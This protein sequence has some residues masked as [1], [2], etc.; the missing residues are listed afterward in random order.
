MKREDDENAM[1]ITQQFRSGEAMVYDF[2]SVAGR[3]T[4]RVSGRG[5]EETGPPSEWRIEA[6]TSTSPESVVVAEW[7]PT[8][9]DALRAVGRA[10]RAKSVAH[11]LPGIDWESVARAMSAVRAL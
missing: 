9:A 5:G 7:G 4:V 3:L 8:R 6:C 10:W 11:D 1:R 2:R